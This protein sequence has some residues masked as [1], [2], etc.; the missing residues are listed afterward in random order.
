MITAIRTIYRV[1]NR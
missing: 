1:N